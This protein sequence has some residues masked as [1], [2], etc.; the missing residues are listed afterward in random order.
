M[1][2]PRLFFRANA[3]KHFKSSI[4]LDSRFRGNDMIFFR[5]SGRRPGIYE[6]N[7]FAHGFFS[8]QCLGGYAVL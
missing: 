5:H 1:L 3:L 6:F 8:V 2:L 4:G 7:A